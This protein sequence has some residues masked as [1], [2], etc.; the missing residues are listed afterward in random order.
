M[1]GRVHSPVPQVRTEAVPSCLEPPPPTGAGGLSVGVASEGNPTD[2]RIRSGPAGVTRG[3]S[4][5][6]HQVAPINVLPSGNAFRAA[7]VLG[8]LPRLRP[9]DLAHP[10]RA[11]T[12]L[13]APGLSAAPMRVVGRAAIRRNLRAA[14]PL[15]ALIQF[16]IAELRAPPGVPMITMQDSTLDQALRAYP[17]AYLVGM[18]TSEIERRNR[19]ARAAYRSAVGCC[20]ATHW[21]AESIVEDYG[22]NPD[23]VHVVGLAPNFEAPTAPIIRDWSRPRFLFVGVDWRRKNGTAVLEAFARVRVEHPTA[24]LDVVGEHPRLHAD[25][26]RL[27]GR[28]RLEEPDERRQMQDL[29]TTATVCVIPS[30]HEP[31][32]IAYLDAGVVGVPSIGTTNGGA[33]TMIGDGGVVVDPHS[34][35]ALPEAMLRLANP[36]VAAQLGARAQR[37][38]QQFTWGKVAQRML[39]VL[40]LPGTDRSQLADFL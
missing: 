28:L 27:H 14:A 8:V 30:L 1:T 35:R 39:R 18:R 40:D 31:A 21:A 36:A 9:S 17:W 5:L 13:W 11:L 6:G 4:E 2:L 22:I 23:K 26:I 20:V 12:R 29:F 37:H 33:R 32:G 25:G 38:A 15:D 10:G 19:A 34:P 3:L 7:M 24:T 16:G